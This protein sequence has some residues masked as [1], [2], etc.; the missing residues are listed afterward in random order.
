MIAMLMTGNERDGM[1]SLNGIMFRGSI[2]VVAVVFACSLVAGA[3]AVDPKQLYVQS[4]DAMYNLDF[5]TAQRGY[6]TL[7]RDYPENPDY[8]NA[9][10]SSI[11]LKITFDQQKLN[12]E[13][14][15]SKSSFGT[16]E[17]RDAVNPADEKRLRETIS[18]AIAKA[19]VILKK[20]PRDVRALY[21]KGISNAT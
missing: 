13:S 17:S 8:W 3:A 19:D 11:W 2:L 14:F 1:L 21:A 10:A 18:T 15:S 7:T 20:N 4:T 12:I 16:K 6:E 5:N 9:L